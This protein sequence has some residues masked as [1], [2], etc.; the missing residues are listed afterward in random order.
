MPWTRAGS[1]GGLAYSLQ[2][3]IDESEGLHLVDAQVGSSD[4]P[5][6]WVEDNAVGM[7]CLL[8]ILVRAGAD[9][10]PRAAHGTNASIGLDWQYDEVT[11]DV[12]GHDHISSGRIDRQVG[13]DRAVQRLPIEKP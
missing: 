12:V 3:A 9:V 11:A 8:A 7:W 10:L 5:T 13:R 1:D 6:I 4:E 2:P